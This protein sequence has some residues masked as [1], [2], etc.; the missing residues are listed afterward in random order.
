MPAM[1]YLP[2]ELII[3]EILLRLP[4]K[5]LLRFRCVCKAWRDTA[6]GDASFSEAHT[7]R[8]RQQNRR[9]STLLIAPYITQVDNDGDFIDEYAIPGQYLW[10]ENQR[11]D[12]VVTLLHDMAWFPAGDCNF[13]RRGGTGSR[14]V[15][16]SSCCPTPRAPCA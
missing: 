9:P 3:S 1:P 14:T 8:L 11:Q 4:V 6:S 13:A 12:G 15:T 10:E 5:S 2:H 16:G 7:R